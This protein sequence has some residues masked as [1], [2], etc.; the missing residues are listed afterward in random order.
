MAIDRRDFLKATAAL[1]TLGA[2]T[3]CASLS[4]ARKAGPKVVIVGAGFGGAT[5]ARYLKAWDP[6]IDITLIEA[7]RDFISCPF[8]NTVLAGMNN[9]ESLTFSYDHLRNIVDSF[10]QDRVTAIDSVKRRVRTASGLHFD[11]DRL[12][13]AG[14]VEFLFDKVPGYTEAAQRTIKHAWKA[15]VEQTGVLRQQLAAIP[16]GGVFVMSIPRMPFR[17]PPA[18]YERACLVANYFKNTKP[19]A[20]VIVLDSNPDIVVMK[21]L[22]LTAW[23]KH[24]GFET[25]NSMI[26][27]RPDNDIHQLDAKKMVVHTNFDDISGDVINII[28]PMRAAALTEL[29]GARASDNGH[30]CPIDYR[31]FEST[32]V[33]N[34]HVLGDS[35]LSV[36]PKSGSVANNTGKMCAAALVELLNNRWPDNAP[37]VTNTCYAASTDHT[38]FN[39][40]AVFRYDPVAKNMVA[41]LG[42]S[43]ISKQESELEFS[44]M[45]SWA[46]NV[47]A[48]SLGLPEGYRY[49]TKF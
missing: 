43:G 36:F 30:W 31:T 29:A 40:A 2:L 22:F 28:P 24:Y 12:V 18:P 1:G 21:Q 23:K 20:K 13:L 11:Y 46:K 45:E 14:G 5:C 35:A 34:V 48:D 25:A 10:V 44:Y 27:Y 19:R 39:V 26:D 47:W 38:A 17:C 7:N 33:P 9:L 37:V 32:I 16:D 41:E 3:G 8:S 4:T 6:N 42:G 15:S 49:T